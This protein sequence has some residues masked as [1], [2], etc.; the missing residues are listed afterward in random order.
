MT[1]P[2][3]TWL[4]EPLP[5]DVAR[6]LANVCEH[7]AVACVA[8]MPDVHLS[9]DVCVGVAVGSVSHLLPQAVGGDIGCG[10]A[11]V[12]FSVEADVLS[13]RLVAAR[14]LHGLERA[15]P[16]LTFPGKRALPAA[17]E[18]LPLSD[19]SLERLRARDGARE[20]GT[21]GRG[22]HFVELQSDDAGALW[23]MV[24]SGSRAVGQA[25]RA[26]HTR[27]ADGKTL[28]AL[29]ADSPQGRAYLQDHD[30]AL[31]YAAA[32]RDA[33]VQAACGV[34][35][36]V[37][38]AEADADVLRCHHNHV[39]RE[40]H[41][42]DLWVHRKGAIPAGEGEA[43]IIPGSMGAES[44]HTVGRGVAAALG[45][46]SHGA[47]RRFSRTEARERIGQRTLEREMEGI[48]FDR[49]KVDGLRDEAPGAYK[50]IGAVMRA[51]RELT[52]IVRTLRPRLSFKAV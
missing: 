18:A 44:H 46:S 11:A 10:M 8:A 17:L 30:F 34:V 23:L 7:P 25:V 33:L 29:E 39:R 28:V 5:Q 48:W 51:Q 9:H 4:A 35:A 42:V 38:K 21:L 36:D 27:E 49:R 12:R 22:N 45:S 43:G 41:G 52:R 50:D 15:I 26:A 3:H 14:V 16:S 19:A 47:G 37:L 40:R 6:A 31:A 13:D 1:A 32:N 2:L 24:H 20:L